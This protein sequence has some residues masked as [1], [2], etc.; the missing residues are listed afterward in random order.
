VL[1][2]GNAFCRSP[3]LRRKAP[4]SFGN[5]LSAKCRRTAPAFPGELEGVQC[6]NIEFAT[7]RR[8]TTSPSR[9]LDLCAKMIMLRS[10]MLRGYA[11]AI[12]QLRQGRRLVARLRP[13][14]PPELPPTKRRVLR[15]KLRGE[16]LEPR[17]ALPMHVVSVVVLSLPPQWATPWRPGCE[18]PGRSRE[19]DRVTTPGYTVCHG[20]HT[21]IGAGVR[22]V[23][24]G[25]TQNTKKLN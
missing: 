16:P 25:N 18:A 5:T 6:P 21:V 9:R 22:G 20:Y 3:N 15:Y 1:F 23:P 13:T 14:R 10:S 19:P 24:A 11:T 7:S 17:P 2:G 8:M 12:Y 4:R